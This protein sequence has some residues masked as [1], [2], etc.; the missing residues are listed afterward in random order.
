MYAIA[1]FATA[2]VF[3]ATLFIYDALRD[4]KSRTAKSDLD[5]TPDHHIDA[6]RKSA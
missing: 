4:H 5:I 2:F 1:F 3:S 6:Y